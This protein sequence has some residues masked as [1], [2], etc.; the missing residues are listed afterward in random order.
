MKVLHKVSHPNIWDL[1]IEFEIRVW[2]LTKN[3]V[4]IVSFHPEVKRKYPEGYF[5][6]TVDEM[7]LVIYPQYDL[8]DWI[9]P[10]HFGIASPK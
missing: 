3:E 1:K 7:E 5:I 10:D 8:C 6:V 2:Y 4:P 9:E